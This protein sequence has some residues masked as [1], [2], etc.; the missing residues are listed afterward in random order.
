MKVRRLFKATFLWLGLLALPCLTPWALAAF[1]SG[2]TGADGAFEPTANTALQVPESGVF[3]F[4]TVNIPTGVTVTF[5]KNSKNT[6]VTIL[7]TGDVAVTG[8]IDVSGSSSGAFSANGAGGPGG[9]DG[10]VGG[11]MQ[12]NGYRGQGP[13]AGAG[14]AGITTQAYAACGGGGGFAG[15]GGNGGSYSNIAIGG[16]GGIAY[17][18]DG[19]LPM[20]GGSGGGGGGGTTEYKGGAGGAG[21]GAI[22]IASSGTLTVNGSIYANGGNGSN[23]ANPNLYA[24]AGGGGSG[25]SL[26]LIANTIAGNGAISATAGNGA[27]TWS[28]GGG[29]GA[30]GRIRL[31][32]WNFTRTAGTSPTSSV[33]WSPFA[34]APAVLPSLGITSL[35]GIAVPAIPKG[36]PKNPDIMFPAGMKNPITVVVTANNIPV[37]TVVTVRMLP[38]QGNSATSATATL[39]GSESLS[40]S[41][42]Q[43]TLPTAYPSLITVSA[44][45]QAVAS[46]GSPIYA[47]GERVDKIRVSASIGGES[48]VTYITESGR[49]IAVKPYGS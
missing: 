9:F 25:G 8:A 36:D 40:T 18:N 10:G 22:L 48:A 13:G 7:S 24:G 49:E 37:G 14:G 28:C 4:T 20:I 44:T 43:L 2:S 16:N 17:G 35:G 29:K 12:G 5:K 23:G 6:P 19:Q 33:K 27:G 42:V 46:N 32:A 34:I 31:E 38:S 41:S 26:S 21:G 15:N 3:N 11:W 1:N 30:D 45:Y 47:E 39:S